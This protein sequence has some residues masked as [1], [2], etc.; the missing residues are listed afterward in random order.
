LTI[1]GRAV[2]KQGLFLCTGLYCADYI[3]T[4]LFLIYFHTKIF[5]LLLPDTRL[6]FFIIKIFLYPEREGP[7]FSTEK[8]SFSSERLSIFHAFFPA[9]V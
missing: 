7:V 8:I 9:A 1:K 2:W 3:F 5:L 6:V 4:K